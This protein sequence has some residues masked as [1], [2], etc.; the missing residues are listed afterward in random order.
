MS[1]ISPATSSHATHQTSRRGS[2]RRTSIVACDSEVPTALILETEDDDEGGQISC[3]SEIIGDS[4]PWQHKFVIF[5][6]IVY[7]ISPFQNYG[8]GT[9]FST[10]NDSM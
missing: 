3:I 6:M 5:Y 4:G 7:L 1:L 2:I 10:Q 8:I 9:F